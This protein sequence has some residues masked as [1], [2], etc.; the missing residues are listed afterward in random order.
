MRLS[1]LLFVTL[2]VSFSSCKESREEQIARMVEE[3]SGKEIRFPEKSVFT[4]Q[5]TDTVGA[6]A[7]GA[8]YK[9]LVYVDSVGCMSCRL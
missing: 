9:V 4:I 8:P 6:P 5:L 7:V 2:L 1:I 3:W